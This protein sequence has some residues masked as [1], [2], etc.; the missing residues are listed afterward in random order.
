MAPTY[1][2]YKSNKTSEPNDNK[3]S[4]LVIPSKKSDL[5]PQRKIPIDFAKRIASSNKLSTISTA[6]VINK[7]TIHLPKEP[8]IRVLNNSPKTVDW[9]NKFLKLKHMYDDLV[10]IV[11]DINLKFDGVDEFIGKCT[12][13][14]RY[15]YL[16]DDQEDNLCDSCANNGSN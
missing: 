13:C 7:P 12:K 14:D 9:K 3:T 4:E 1:F 15:I 8:I 10:G 11:E 6:K 2:K 16:D 5:I